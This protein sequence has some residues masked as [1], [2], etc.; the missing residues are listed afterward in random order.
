MT[1]KEQIL[2]A[3]QALCVK[4][5]Y[6][7]SD[8]Y[9]KALERCGGDDALAGE[10]VEA[11]EADKFVSDLRYASAFAREKSAISGWGSVKIRYAL[12]RKGISESDIAAGLAEIDLPASS[13]RLASLL[14]AKWKSLAEDPQG[15]LKLIRFALS[16][17]YEYSE[18]EAAINDLTR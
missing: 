16:R 8:I 7:V 18:I 4:R 11:L 9:R 12:R 1:S 6:C 5:E 2:S 10:L 3:L 13:K 14:A 15:R 17:G